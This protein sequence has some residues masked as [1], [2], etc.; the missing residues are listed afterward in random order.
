MFHLEKQIDDWCK[1]AAAGHAGPDAAAELKD[2]LYCEIEELRQ[3]GFSEKDAFDAATRQLGDVGKLAAK[4]LCLPGNDKSTAM[5]LN[6]SKAMSPIKVALMMLVQSLVWAAVMILAA[7]TLSGT[8]Y[9]KQVFNYL[10]A[11]WFVSWLMTLV[12]IDYRKA[13]KAEC[14]FFRRVFNR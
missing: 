12:L 2:H 7:S 8:D 11:G 5:L 9:G 4:K 1:T 10:F 3:Q 14:A 6:G 13:M